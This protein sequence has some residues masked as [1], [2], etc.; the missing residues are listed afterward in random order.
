MENA[1]QAT[2]INFELLIL[3]KSKLTKENEIKNTVNKKIE[4][5][6]CGD[7]VIMSSMEKTAQ[8]EKQFYEEA[9]FNLVLDASDVNQN[10]VQDKYLCEL[11]KTPNGLDCIPKEISKLL[12]RQTG[13]TNFAKAYLELYKKQ[14][15]LY[16]NTFKGIELDIEEHLKCLPN[17]EL[18]AEELIQN[19]AKLYYLFSNPID[20]SNKEAN[21]FIWINLSNSTKQF[22][23]LSEVNDLDLNNDHDEEEDDEFSEQKLLDSTAE[24]REHLLEMNIEEESIEERDPEIEEFSEKFR[25]VYENQFK[26]FL[27]SMSKSE[28]IYATSLPTK[29]YCKDTFDD[30]SMN[31]TT[32]LFYFDGLELDEN[33]NINA[34]MAHTFDKTETCYFSPYFCKKYGPYYRTTLFCCLYNVGRK[35]DS[36]PENFFLDLPVDLYNQIDMD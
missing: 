36:M 18:N 7:I 33:G 4:K 22:Y 26:N 3:N 9:V 32:L 27:K 20:N 31:S 15:S 8:N 29:K 2:G 34:V 30:D 17:A 24:L 5:L 25:N 13:D 14:F 35:E 6:K 16:K 1:N 23:Y 19:K 21:F 10:E 28:T 12:F 11:T